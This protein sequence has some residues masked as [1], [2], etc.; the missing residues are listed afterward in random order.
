MVGTLGKIVVVTAGT[1]VRCIATSLNVNTVYF[2]AV[3][4]QVGQQMYIGLV[5]MVKATL[6]GVLKIVQKPLATPTT[7][8]SWP[9]QHSVA[10]AG[11]DLSAV[12]IDADSNGDGLLVSYVI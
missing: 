2:S 8:D 4:G 5:N 12:W 1:P 3:S 11:I 9:V 10:P 7:L 6:V